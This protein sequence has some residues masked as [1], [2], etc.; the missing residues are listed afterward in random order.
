MLFLRD[1]RI[2]STSYSPSFACHVL[3]NSVKWYDLLLSIT[4]HQKLA[5]QDTLPLELASERSHTEALFDTFMKP[6]SISYSWCASFLG[7]DGLLL[8]LPELFAL[9]F[10]HAR[11]PRWARDNLRA[12]PVSGDVS[13]ISSTAQFLNKIDVF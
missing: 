9:A 4:P 8:G 6:N 7:A 1:W 3:S 10:S 2:S 13:A 11:S 12:W 5:S